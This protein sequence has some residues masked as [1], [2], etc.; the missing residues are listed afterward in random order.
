MY[1]SPVQNFRAEKLYDKPKIENY[2]YCIDWADHK[3]QRNKKKS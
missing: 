3:A 1:H 2:F